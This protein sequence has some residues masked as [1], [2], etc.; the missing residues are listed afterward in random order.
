L[1]SETDLR[2]Q[3]ALAAIQTPLARRDAAQVERVRARAAVASA[4]TLA[5]GNV[6]KAVLDAHA[7]A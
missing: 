6:G 2:S 7:L 5:A 1:I 4:R 3:S